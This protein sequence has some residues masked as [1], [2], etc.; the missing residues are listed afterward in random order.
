MSYSFNCDLC[1]S[2]FTSKSRKKHL[3][4]KQHKFLSSLIIYRYFIINPE[5]LQ[6]K[7]I[8]KKCILEHKK[9]F[10]FYLVMCKLK[11]H[12]SEVI[13]IVKNDKYYWFPQS[14]PVDLDKFILSKIDALERPGRLFSHVSETTF[15]F[16]STPDK[17]TYE[18]Y[19]TIP[20]PM[21]ERRF[22]ILLSRNPEL[23]QIF[24]NS[25]HPLIRK[26]NYINKDEHDDEQ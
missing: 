7:D 26:Y 14:A 10:E 22:I 18:H 2:L 16:I 15:T 3:K 23:A 24:E 8:F 1:D 11:L 20:K 19:L 25:T 17:I 21:I 9:N 5:L 4:S 6:I 12:F 13:V